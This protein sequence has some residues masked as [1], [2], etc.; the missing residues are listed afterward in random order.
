MRDELKQALQARWEDSLRERA[1]IQ[2]HSPVPL[3]DE[4]LAAHQELAELPRREPISQISPGTT[5]APIR[6][7]G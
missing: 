3:L 1:A 6:H 2:P 5:T 4:M 7:V